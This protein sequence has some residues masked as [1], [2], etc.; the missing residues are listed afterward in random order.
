MVNVKKLE[1]ERFH[2]LASSSAGLKSRE[3]LGT[4]PEE[5]AEASRPPERFSSA[6]DATIPHESFSSLAAVHLIFF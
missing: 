6:L 5:A 4:S 1:I 3:T 2:N